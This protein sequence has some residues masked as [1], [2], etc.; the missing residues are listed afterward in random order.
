IQNRLHFIIASTKHIKKE[1]YKQIVKKL[2]WHL[3]TIKASVEMDKL[4]S[5][6]DKLEGVENF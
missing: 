3:Y 1:Q 2:D 6:N 4:I 5:H